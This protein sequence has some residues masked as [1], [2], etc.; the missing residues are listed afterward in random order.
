MQ[1][2]KTVPIESQFVLSRKR[3]KQQRGQSIQIKQVYH[4]SQ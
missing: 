4:I 3:L 1:H 2:R